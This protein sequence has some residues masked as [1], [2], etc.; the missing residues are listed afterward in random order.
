MTQNKGVVGVNRIST[1]DSLSRQLEA[2]LKGQRRSDEAIFWFGLFWNSGPQSDL[3][4]AMCLTKYDPSLYEIRL[5]P[6]YKFD[7]GRHE[8]LTPATDPEIVYCHSLL[9]GWY[10]SVHRPLREYPLLPIRFDDVKEDDVVIC[11]PG[12]QFPCIEA[13]WP[14]RVFKHHG[15]LGV[16]CAEDPTTRA[17][18]PFR[19]DPNGYIVGFR[20]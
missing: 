7:P 4:R 13:D 12:R 3:Y 9:K 20:R 8:I 14:C 17:F 1:A 16:P 18:H 5:K 15:D 10:E 11:G 6:G 19:P 2:V